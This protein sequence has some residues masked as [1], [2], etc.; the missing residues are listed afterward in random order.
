MNKNDLREEV[1]AWVKDAGE[2]HV[3]EQLMSE[4]KA[5]TTRTRLVKG[6]YPNPLIKGLLADA[7]E[8]VLRANGRIKEPRTA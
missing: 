4:V 1:N 3:E 5:P 2:F 7:V 6:N 8:K